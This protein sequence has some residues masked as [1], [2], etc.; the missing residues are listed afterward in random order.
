MATKTVATG[1]TEQGRRALLHFIADN[2]SDSTL[3]HL[4]SGWESDVTFESDNEGHIEI[5]GAHTSTRN[6]VTR[7]F[8]GDEVELEDMEADAD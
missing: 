7:R 2:V 6:P 3:G 4:L 8:S 5:R 1:L